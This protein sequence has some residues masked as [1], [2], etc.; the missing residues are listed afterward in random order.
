M[1]APAAEERHCQTRFIVC[2]YVSV[3]A[4]NLSSTFLFRYILCLTFF[5]ALSI[6]PRPLADMLYNFHL[7]LYLLYLAQYL[8]LPPFSLS[9]S[10]PAITTMVTLVLI[11][12]SDPSGGCN[13][14]F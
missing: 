1:T 12:C 10:H 13:N 7:K 3:P 9:L 4:K 6:N 2:V 11:A 14:Y 5:L 8:S